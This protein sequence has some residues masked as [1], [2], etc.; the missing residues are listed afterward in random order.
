M[1]E[2]WKQAWA[3]SLEYWARQWRKWI[4]LWIIVSLGLAAVL[5]AD[6]ATAPF[7]F[8]E[9]QPSN[10]PSVI[11]AFHV[12][13]QSFIQSLPQLLAV[14]VG[15][16]VVTAVLASIWSKRSA[17]RFRPVSAIT[18]GGLLLVVA[19]SLMA[20]AGA[21]KGPASWS[22][23]LRTIVLVGVGNV[24]VVPQLFWIWPL[25][26]TGTSW[27]NLVAR[28]LF[29]GLALAWTWVLGLVVSEMLAAAFGWMAPVAVGEAIFSF[30]TTANAALCFAA[31]RRY[32]RLLATPSAAGPPLRRLP[33]ITKSGRSGSGAP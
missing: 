7:V 25:R 11:K 28:H 26:G 27:R 30:L 13:V 5:V 29:D 1:S 32:G 9:I 14:G 24:V 21:P 31:A 4:G 20:V 22:A 16:L 17:R 15:A 10:D 18:W 12:N 23:E 6:P 19:M 2:V 33:L 3:E 8:L